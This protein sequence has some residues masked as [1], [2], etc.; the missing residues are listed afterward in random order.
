MGTPAATTW[1][2][3]SAGNLSPAESGYPPGATAR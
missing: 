3:S 1:T 2:F